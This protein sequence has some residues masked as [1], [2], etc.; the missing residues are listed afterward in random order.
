MKKIFYECQSIEQMKKDTMLEAR[1]E[2]EKRQI[3]LLKQ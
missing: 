3:I 2:A 1:A